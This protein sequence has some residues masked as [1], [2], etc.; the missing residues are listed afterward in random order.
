[1]CRRGEGS[2]IIDRAWGD[3]DVYVV[4]SERRERMPVNMRWGGDS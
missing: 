2:S 3:T 1:M 4:W